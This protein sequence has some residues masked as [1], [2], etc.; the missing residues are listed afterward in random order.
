MRLKMRCICTTN[1]KLQFKNETEVRNQNQDDTWYELVTHL[2][3]LTL[4]SLTIRIS[5]SVF[6]VATVLA[7]ARTYC[8]SKSD[9]LE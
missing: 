7:N 1:K 8:M 6:T 4:L 5:T 9:T 2:R 3:C